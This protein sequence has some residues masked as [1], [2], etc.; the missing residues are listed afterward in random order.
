MLRLPRHNNITLSLV[1]VDNI[2]AFQNALHLVMLGFKIAFFCGRKN[3]HR[4]EENKTLPKPP[5]NILNDVLFSS[6]PN[7][8]VLFSERSRN[9]AAWIRLSFYKL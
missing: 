9:A 8:Y 4:I 5:I 7:V 3:V 2:Y 1:I 6:S